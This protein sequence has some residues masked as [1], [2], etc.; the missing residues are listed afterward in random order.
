M[1]LCSSLQINIGS[2]EFFISNI[3]SLV[4]WRRVL[5]F[6]ESKERYCFGKLFR[7]KGHSLVPEP[8]LSITGIRGD[9]LIT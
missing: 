8:P 1:N 3:L 6:S 9:R 5:L 7:E 2:K 4:F